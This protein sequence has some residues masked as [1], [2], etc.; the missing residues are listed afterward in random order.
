MKLGDF[1]MPL[2]PPGSEWAKTLK[3]DLEQIPDFWKKEP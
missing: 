3:K 1:T 2:H